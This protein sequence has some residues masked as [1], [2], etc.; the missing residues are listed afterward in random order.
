MHC[1]DVERQLNAY[2]EG[3]LSLQRQQDIGRHLDGCPGCRQSLNSAKRLINALR[4]LPAPANTPGFEDRVLAAARA[5]EERPTPAPSRRRVN[6]RIGMALAASFLAG[7]FV[8]RMP[9][10]ESPQAPAQLAA[11]DVGLD[12]AQP[13]RLAFNTPRAF[14]AVEVSIELPDQLELQGYPR[15]R[16]IRWRTSLVEGKN[17][18]TLPVIARQPGDGVITARIRS[19]DKIKQFTV[20]TRARRPDE[21]RDASGKAI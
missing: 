2:L 11:G 14:G 13:V 10:T 17:V 21:T 12:R 5:A 16:H 7:I 6:V 9:L 19:G 3:D 20:L 18:L 15:Q 1:A 8:A 4:V